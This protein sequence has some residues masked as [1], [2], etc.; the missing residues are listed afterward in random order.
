MICD[1]TDNY[2][3][4]HADIMARELLNENLSTYTIHDVAYKPKCPV[5]IIEE[6][7]PIE[8]AKRL[9]RAG[10]AVTIKDRP[11]IVDLV[12]RTYGRMFNYDVTDTEENFHFTSNPLSSYR[13]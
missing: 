10:K 3:K 13:E 2:N 6:S 5:D 9:V 8:V 1:A 11:A 7:Q 4:Q 12:R